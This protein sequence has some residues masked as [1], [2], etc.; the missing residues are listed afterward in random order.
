MNFGDKMRG[1]MFCT[2]VQCSVCSYCE[3]FY[4]FPG[5][6]QSKILADDLNT[7]G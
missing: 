6:P 2:F 5:K 4:V 1:I 3:G 7:L